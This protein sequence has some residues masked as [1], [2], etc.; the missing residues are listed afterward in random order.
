MARDLQYKECNQKIRTMFA[1]II[2]D[3][4]AVV[5]LV[6]LVSCWMYAL[7]PENKDEE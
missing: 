7:T 1:D 3:L 4:F 5:F 2:L 6:G